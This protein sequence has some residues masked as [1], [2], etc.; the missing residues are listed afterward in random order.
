MAKFGSKIQKTFFAEI[1]SENDLE[2]GDAC[3]DS[4]I[5][6]VRSTN[7]SSRKVNYALELVSEML[8]I[9]VGFIEMNFSA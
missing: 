9:S 1:P 4:K 8:K 2:E 6:L 7:F 5:L 3:R